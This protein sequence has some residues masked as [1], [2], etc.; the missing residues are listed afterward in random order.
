MENKIV[1]SVSNL[2]VQPPEQDIDRSAWSG[3]RRWRVDIS[4]SHH[5]FI[6]DHERDYFLQEL[7]RG[8]KII[9]VGEM[10]LTSK[11][12]AITKVR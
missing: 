7:A 4:Y 11:F 12:L 10:V 5:V 8:K 9:K 2:L 3:A 1:K 6:N